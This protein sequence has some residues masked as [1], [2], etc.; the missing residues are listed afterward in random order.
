MIEWLRFV[1]HG[2]L[3][4]FLAQGWEIVDELHGTNHGNWST[5]MRW[6]GEGDPS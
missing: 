5:L 1:P 3:C 4:L 2:Q 6:T